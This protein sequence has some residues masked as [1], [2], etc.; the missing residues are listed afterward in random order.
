LISTDFLETELATCLVKVVDFLDGALISFSVSLSSESD[1]SFF[2]IL[3][4][5]LVAGFVVSGVLELVV[6]K[7]QLFL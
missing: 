6:F 2:I 7:M 4:T 5:D 3:A 1:S